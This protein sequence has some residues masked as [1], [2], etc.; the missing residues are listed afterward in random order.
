MLIGEARSQLFPT[1]T[2]S[3]FYTWSRSPS[4]AG[5]ATTTGNTGTTTGTGGVATGTSVVATRNNVTTFTSLP[6]DVSWEPDLWGRVRSAINQATY[7]SQLSAADLENER[8]TEQSSLAVYFFE[9]RGQDALQKLYNETIA[10]DKKSLEYTRAQYETGV[11]DQIS[12]VEAQNTLQT[13]QANATNLG[14]L[15]S[16]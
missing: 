16:V 13:A 12:V 1:L 14:V 6:F 7:N 11:G 4:I 3:P 2:V 10:A 5:V 9:I 15:R 8:L